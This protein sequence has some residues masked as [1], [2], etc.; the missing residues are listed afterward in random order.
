MATSIQFYGIEDALNAFKNRDCPNWGLFQGRQF[1]FKSRPGDDMAASEALLTEILESLANNP[2]IYTLKVF[3]NP[4]KINERTP[5]D[6]S[7]NFKLLDE[8]ELTR[9]KETRYYSANRGIS[10]MDELENRINKILDILEGDEDEEKAAIQ[11]AQQQQNWDNIIMGYLEN[12][13]KIGEL[14]NSLGGVKGLLTGE[15]MTPAMLG[16]VVQMGQNNAAAGPD[17][18]GNAGNLSQEQQ[19]QRLS[20]ALDILGNNDPGIIEHLE[21]LAELS[22]KKPDT[23]KMAI[24]MLEGM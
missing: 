10:R 5:C 6:G 22:I 12:P 3:E 24:K 7:F 11:G 20:T 4:D 15:A 19:M 13:Q 1:L 21:K 17:L 2:V 23:F 18:P 16:A 9:R 14:V 8:E